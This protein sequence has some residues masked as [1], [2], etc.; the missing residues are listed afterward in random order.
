MMTEIIRNNS[1]HQLELFFE[2]GDP[3]FDD[4]F[5]LQN[6]LY[7]AIKYNAA[8]CADFLLSTAGREH[9]LHL[10]ETL[11]YRD[12]VGG[13]R[14]IRPVLQIGAEL[15]GYETMGV[16]LKY[17]KNRI[18]E[19]DKKGMTAVHYAV[20]ER[21]IG[22]LTALAEQG[23][24]LYSVDFN[25]RSPVRIAVQKK[26]WDAVCVLIKYKA[27]MST[28]NDNGNTPLHNAVW[29]GNYNVVAELLHNWPYMDI[30]N[31]Y[32]STPLIYA[33]RRNNLRLIK[34]LVEHGADVYHE[35]KRGNTPLSL[36]KGEAADFLKTIK[37]K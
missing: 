4:T 18:K 11:Y 16:L 12:A 34:L 2:L 7:S 3:C 9:G 15:S 32:G 37:K 14:G 27:D 6:M 28:F 5:R 29:K 35:N 33:V 21:N 30:E 20:Q 24:P 8:Q 1:Y 22:A 31:D 13:S 26:Y 19:W 10:K 25:R 17:F 36:A 23:A